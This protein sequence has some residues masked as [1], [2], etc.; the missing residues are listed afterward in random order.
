MSR[1]SQLSPDN[2]L[3][4][5]QLRNSAVSL[6]DLSRS[7]QVKKSSRRALLQMLAKLKKRGLLEEISRERFVLRRAPAPQTSFKPRP[8]ARRAFCR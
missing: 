1:S 4:F 2:I 8:P 3:R 6:E 7:L 5:L